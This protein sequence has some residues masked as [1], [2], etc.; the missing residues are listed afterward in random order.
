MWT[1][2]N[3][4]SL[5]TLI[6]RFNATQYILNGIFLW[7]FFWKNKYIRIANENLERKTNEA[8]C[9]L[10]YQIED[11]LQ[12]YVEEWYLHKYGSIKETSPQ[13]RKLPIMYNGMRCYKVDIKTKEGMSINGSQ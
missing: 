4:S 5:P 10:F 7:E 1:I 12:S 11:I 13:K 9:N 8:G 3:I 2:I 6:F